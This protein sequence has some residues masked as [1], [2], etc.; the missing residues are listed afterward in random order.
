M[1]LVNISRDSSC[2]IIKEVQNN[3]NRVVIT[4]PITKQSINELVVAFVDDTDFFANREDPIQVMRNILEEYRS[5]FEATGG[6]IKFEK[7]FCFA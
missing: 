6:K 4:S 2:I 7:I 5:S 3:N 1:L